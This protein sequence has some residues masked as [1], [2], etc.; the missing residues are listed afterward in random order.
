MIGRPSRICAKRF[1][2]NRVSCRGGD[3]T[4]S[5][6]YAYVKTNVY[7]IRN[8][9]YSIQLFMAGNHR[10][11]DWNQKKT[12]FM[13][14]RILCLSHSLTLYPFLNLVSLF[15]HIYIHPLVYFH[16]N[17]QSIPN[18][19]TAFFFLSKY[20][21]KIEFMNWI[22]VTIH[23]RRRHSLF[24][25]SSIHWANV[26]LGCPFHSYVCIQHVLMF[27][28]PI[29]HK[30]SCIKRWKNHFFIVAESIENIISINQPAD[31]LKSVCW[32]NVH[33]S[34]VEKTANDE[35]DDDWQSHRV[36]SFVSE[37]DEKKIIKWIW[38]WMID[39]SGQSLFPAD[40][41]N[42]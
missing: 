22:F 19:Y 14:V 16:K 31:R 11:Y 40:Y 39:A 24:I 1:T 5:T 23:G 18:A 32:K 35:Y 26:T 4:V 34:I 20:Q 42:Q 27:H 3:C 6:A 2:F 13:S 37:S 8:T 29:F 36:C 12:T 33:R 30:I 28:W 9:E 25:V 21:P 38:N 10:F 41:V 17:I 15:V 7:L